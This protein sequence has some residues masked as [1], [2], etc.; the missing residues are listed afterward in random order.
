MDNDRVKCT[1]YQFLNVLWRLI[2]DIYMF[3]MTGSQGFPGTPGS[4][5]ETGATG[6]VAQTGATGFQGP[7]GYPGAIGR[8][9]AAGRQGPVGVT[10]AVGRTGVQG[11][12]G[13]L[14]GA[15]PPGATGH[16]GH[17]GTVGPTGETGTQIANLNYCPLVWINRNKNDLARLEKVQERVVRLIF[18]DKMSAYIDLLERAGVPSVLI[19]WQR[20]LLPKSIKPS[21]VYLHYTNKTSL[22]RK[23]YHTI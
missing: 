4:S 23:S 11:G 6:A 21:M 8:P 10:G 19:R 17:T 16:I 5:G 18:N 12:T 3:M 14:G 15:G 7:V 13:A 9:G 22:M 2:F 20:V 1:L